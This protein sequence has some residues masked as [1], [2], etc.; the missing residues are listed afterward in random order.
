MPILKQHISKRGF[1]IYLRIGNQM[2]VLLRYE[3]IGLLGKGS[4]AQV[5]K[6]F[7]HKHSEYV[8]IKM[9]RNR[10]EFEK[11][12]ENEV[13]IL[14]HLRSEDLDGTGN[15]VHMKATFV[16]RSHTCIVFEMMSTNLYELIKSNQF[17]RSYLLSDI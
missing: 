9:V 5:F 8:A 13:K 17:R 16:F 15:V 11:D 7:D 14:R 2:R 10:A 6:A 4:F 3:L 12:A 1:P